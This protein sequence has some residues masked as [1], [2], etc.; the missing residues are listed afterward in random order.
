LSRRRESFLGLVARSPWWVGVGLAAL[1]YVLS[2]FV[3]P[4]VLREARKGPHAG[5]KFYGCSKY[6]DCRGLISH[7]KSDQNQ[8][9]RCD[10]QG[11]PTVLINHTT[12]WYKHTS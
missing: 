2:T 4:L 10:P 12:V 8:E 3:L 9:S 6:I 11:S 1:V 5:K 7:A